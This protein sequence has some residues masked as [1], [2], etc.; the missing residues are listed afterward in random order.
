M[1]RGEG[2]DHQKCNSCKNKSM[3]KIFIIV[4]FILG[5]FVVPLCN[6]QNEDSIGKTIYRISIK[7]LMITKEE[8]LE[9]AKTYL[10]EEKYYKY[11]QISK[12]R[13]INRNKNSWI[14]YFP[15]K[16]KSFDNSF[17][18][19]ATVNI[20]SVTVEINKMHL[21]AMSSRHHDESLIG[22]EV[23]AECSVFEVN[24]SISGC[25]LYLGG[26][27]DNRLEAVIPKDALESF[28]D[29]CG[30]SLNQ[31]G[32]YYAGKAITITGILKKIEGRP[33]IVIRSPGQIEVNSPNGTVLPQSGSGTH[34]YSG[35][36]GKFNRK[37]Q[38]LWHYYQ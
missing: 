31:I 34:A 22:V 19:K 23:V 9:K 1:E 17:D 18:L 36:F 6:G 26:L 35:V 25:I 10:T 5:I 4:I 29:K 21:S 14:F 15:Q 12:S 16:G 8:A 38:L 30:P 24:D 2:R 37:E 33:M 28:F 11:Y 32:D 7:D 20:M 13:N 3:H 27:G